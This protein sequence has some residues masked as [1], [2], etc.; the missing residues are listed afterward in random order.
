MKL[1]HLKLRS[2]GHENAWNIQ[3]VT[4]SDDDTASAYYIRFTIDGTEYSLERGLSGVNNNNDITLRPIPGAYT[5]LSPGV[6]P[7][8]IYATKDTLPLD[9]LSAKTN[10]MI[11]I[12][13]QTNAT[14]TGIYGSTLIQYRHPGISGTFLGTYQTITITEL[15]KE[16]TG[17][18]AGNFTAV[19]LS[20]STSLSELT[21]SN[22]SFYMFRIATNAASGYWNSL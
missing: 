3:A 20:N 11:K 19:T 8:Y 12:S 1:P 22:G 4:C 2:K 18:V 5:V 21:L 15:G 10:G 9:D 16:N 7:L 6:Y 14:N 17:F 13:S